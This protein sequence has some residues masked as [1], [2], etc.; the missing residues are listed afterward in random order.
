MIGPFDTPLRTAALGILVV[1]AVLLLASLLLR[2]TSWRGH[3][4]ALV[5]TALGLV[6]VSN[7]VH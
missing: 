4:L 6:L 7:A 5:S 1:A 2:R 3:V